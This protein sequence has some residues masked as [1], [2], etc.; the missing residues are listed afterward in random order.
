MPA[1]SI[2]Q[3]EPLQRLE[4]RIARLRRRAEQLEAISGKYWV[5]RRTLFVIGSV[6]ALTF[7]QLSGSTVGIVLAVLAATLFV[8]V[9]ASH[10]KVRDSI[11][12]NELLIKIKATQIARI[13]LEWEQLPVSDQEPPHPEHSFETDLDVTGERSLHRLLDSAVTKEGSRRLKSWLL[14]DQPDPEQIAT[15]QELVRELEPLSLF[16]DKLQLLAAVAGRE[17]GSQQRRSTAQH[18]QLEQW[19]SR[20]LV[21][22][23]EH[24]AVKNSLRPIVIVLALLAAANIV[25]LVLAFSNTIPHVWPIVWLVYAGLMI[26]KQGRI[27]GA[28]DEVQELEKALRR[29][30]SVFSYLE[31]RRYGS[32]PRMAK[33]CRPFLDPEKRPSAE[34][35]RVERIAQVLALRANGPIWFLVN[36]LLPWDFFFTY[37]LDGLRQEIAGLLPRWLDAWYEL[38]ALNSLANFAWLNPRYVFPEIV[39]EPNRFE[40]RE[41]GH[42][43]IKAEHKIC[44]DFAFNEQLRTVILT[45]SNMA[46]KSTFLRTVGVNLCLAYAG[47]PVNADRLQTSLFRLFTCIKVSDSV[48]DGLSYFYAEVKR[49]KQL[50][51][52]AEEQNDLPVMFLIDEIFRGTNNRERHIGSHAFIR[53]LSRCSKAV[54]L[55]ATHDLELTKLADEI[56]GIANFHFREEVGA[57]RMVFDY[58]LHAGPCPTTNALKI[59]QLEGLPVDD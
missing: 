55:I 26:A 5:A 37:R 44:N 22:W 48:Q 13:N 1:K 12:R 27:A 14:N 25:L 42:P 29:F 17:A 45:G 40:A 32:Q 24:G 6:L 10:R 57:G 54:G 47:A 35:K 49:L 33:V 31:A 38:E 30:R 56:P 21:D 15:R 16:R 23:I 43:L 41:I 58:R 51:T 2:A 7:C 9:A 59:M 18:T 28:W 3:S 46:G 11:D 39:S 36:A 20:A 34:L 53:A 8:A 52:A 19:D 4:Q 50:L